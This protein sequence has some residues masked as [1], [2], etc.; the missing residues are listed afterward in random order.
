MSQP[1]AE[2]VALREILDIKEGYLNKAVHAGLIVMSVKDKARLGKLE[3]ELA[4]ATN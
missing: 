1:S 4:S 2:V 3:A